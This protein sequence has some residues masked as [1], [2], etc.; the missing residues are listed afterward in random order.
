MS[1]VFLLGVCMNAQTDKASMLDEA[2]EYVKMLQ[3]QLQVWTKHFFDYRQGS[4]VSSIEVFFMKM[5]G[6]SSCLRERG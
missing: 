4:I 1:Y 6:D 2:I 3:A 5:S